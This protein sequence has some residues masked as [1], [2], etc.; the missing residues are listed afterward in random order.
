MNT[1]L[2]RSPENESNGMFASESKNRPEDEDQI[3][4]WFDELV[5]IWDAL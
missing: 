3:D 1:E 2:L 5:G 4:A